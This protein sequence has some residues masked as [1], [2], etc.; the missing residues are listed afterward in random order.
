VFLKN[1]FNPGF[2]DDFSIEIVQQGEDL[3]T[4]YE[5]Y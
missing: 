5:P 1:F 2:K 3:L 4:V